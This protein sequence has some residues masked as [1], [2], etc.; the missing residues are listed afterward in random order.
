LPAQAPERIATIYQHRYA[1]I[2][3]TTYEHRYS[4]TGRIDHDR[5][6]AVR[7]FNNQ[8]SSGVPA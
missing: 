4:V 6:D 7:E 8:Q 3:T 2:Q 5:T 1:V